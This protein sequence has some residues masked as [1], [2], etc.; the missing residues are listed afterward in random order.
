[1]LVRIFTLPL[2]HAIGCFALLAIAGE[3]MAQSQVPVVGES[4]Q[5]DPSDAYFQAYLSVRSS[6]ELESRGDFAG[7]MEKLNRAQQ[8][9]GTIR[10]YYPEWKP[11]MVGTRSEKTGEAIS[12]VSQKHKTNST[13]TATQSPNWKVESNKQ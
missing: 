4:A 13:V 3:T 12:R 2:A 8:L 9:F 1:M 7:A 11:E 5:F 6:E 10:K